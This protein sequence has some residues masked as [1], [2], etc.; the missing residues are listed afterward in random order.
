[1]A[2]YFDE[3]GNLQ[4]GDQAAANACPTDPDERNRCEGCE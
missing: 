2:V 3:D 1:M 4:F